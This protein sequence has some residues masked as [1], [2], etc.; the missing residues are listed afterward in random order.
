VDD[1][2]LYV[3]I[4]TDEIGGIGAVGANA[5][6]L[7]CGEKHVVRPLRFEKGVD[8]GLVGQIKFVV[9]A[10]YESA[11]AFALQSPDECRANQ[12]AMT[13][14]VDWCGQVE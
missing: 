6:N 14:D 12:S 13:S 1:I 4:V 8:R 9:R 11:R 5:A 2:R 3:K 10:Y 7:R